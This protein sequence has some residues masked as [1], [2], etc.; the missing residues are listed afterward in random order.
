MTPQVLLEVLDE[1]E[2]R[3]R[4]EYARARDW[5]IRISEDPCV[6]VAAPLSL[7]PPVGVDDGR[8]VPM[9][10]CYEDV[11]DCLQVSVPT[12]KRLVASGQ[13]PVVTVGGAR[14]ARRVRRCDLE[15]YYDGLGGGA[16][17]SKD[18]G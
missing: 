3:R 10:L 16:A 14:G 6:S 1:L 18:D 11:A 13:L 8:V 4:R 9:L 7:R 2:R 12:V 5:L 17:G 15:A